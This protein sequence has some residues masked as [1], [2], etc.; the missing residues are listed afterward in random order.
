MG[1]RI[2]F[3]DIKPYYVPQSLSDLHGPLT[4]KIKLRHS[5]MWAPGDG[6]IDIGTVPI[7]H[8][9]PRDWLKTRLRDSTRA[10]R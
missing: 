4:G 8:C 3:R 2:R 9:S 10:D 5:V 7:R 6:I 1:E